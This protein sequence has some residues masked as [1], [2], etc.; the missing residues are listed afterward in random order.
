MMLQ[1]GV[2]LLLLSKRSD[3]ASVSTTSDI[4]GHFLPGR[5]KEVVNN[6]LKAMEEE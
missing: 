6:F 4:Y 1:N 5:L 2:S 3:H